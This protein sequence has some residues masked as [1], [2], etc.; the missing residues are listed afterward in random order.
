MRRRGLNSGY[1]LNTDQRRTA[2]GVITV[3]KHYAER[4]SN[5]FLFT[6]FS[7][8]DASP[9]LWLDATAISANDGD[10]INTWND[11]STSGLNATKPSALSAPIYRPSAMNGLPA[12]EYNSSAGLTTGNTPAWNDF[13]FAIVFQ[14]SLGDQYGRIFDKDFANGFWCGRDTSVASRY[15]GGVKETGSPYGIF[16]TFPDGQP[17][18][19]IRRRT[20]TLHQ[21]YK[22]DEFIT[23]NT[24]GSG[25]LTT[26]GFGIGCY[27][28]GAN[29]SQEHTGLI[30]E[31]VFYPSSLNDTNLT[32]L[33]N[34]LKE[35]YEI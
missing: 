10:S 3:Q 2:A 13:T 8:L 21:L 23:S 19:L 15:G 11:L 18:I 16:G 4:M 26:S 7:P 31:V 30:S 35:K 14:A 27:G 17:N 9:T 12:L 33:A 29:A 24:A 6:A 20:G 25:S 34:Y 32:G 1:T 22:A 28:S 5:R